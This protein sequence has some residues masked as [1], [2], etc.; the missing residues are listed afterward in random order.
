[1]CGCARS[2][3]R[4]EWKMYYSFAF[5]TSAYVRKRMRNKTVIKKNKNRRE[6]GKSSQK[7]TE[8]NRS[9]VC[10]FVCNVGFFAQNFNTREN[11]EYY[12]CVVCVQSLL[13]SLAIRQMSLHLWVYCL[14][15][16][17][18]Y[19]RH[20]HLVGVAVNVF[21]CRCKHSA[22]HFLKSSSFDSIHVHL[23]T[24]DSINKLYILD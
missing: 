2:N 23:R 14:L 15:C 6:I 16:M 22:S 21:F 7:K 24:L 18:Q 3:R 10:L 11:F 12:V 13:R 20:Q 17:L 4:K 8:K 5:I 9:F 19:Q 1:M